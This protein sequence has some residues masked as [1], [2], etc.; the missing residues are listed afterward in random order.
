MK[1]TEGIYRKYGCFDIESFFPP[2][3]PKVCWKPNE[4]ENTRGDWT[5]CCNSSDLCNEKLY[6]ESLALDSYESK[7]ATPVSGKIILKKK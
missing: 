1:S 4:F 7:S 3:S 6:P 2:E 5:L